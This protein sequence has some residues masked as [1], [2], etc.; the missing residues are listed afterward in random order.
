MQTIDTSQW[1]E[2]AERYAALEAAPL[3]AATVPAWLQRWSDLEA[4]IYEE[5][6]EA[7][8]RAHENTADESAEGLFIHY[9]REIQPH[10][11]QARAKLR[12]KLL[13]VTDYTPAESERVFFARFANSQALYRDENVALEAEEQLLCNQHRKLTGGM[14]VEWEGQR[15]TLTVAEQFLRVPDRELRQRAWHLIHQSWLDEREALNQQF[16]DLLA[17][18][19]QIAD[20]AGFPD[21][22]DYYWRARQRLDY[23]PALALDFHAAI[24]QEVVPLATQLYEQ[25]RNTINADR[26]RPWDEF[27]PINQEPLPVVG[28]EALEEGGARIFGAIDPEIGAMFTQ[29]RDGHLDLPVRENKAP[30]GYCRALPV[31]GRSYIFMNGVGRPEDLRTLLHEG[32]HAYHNFRS[33]HLPLLWQRRSPMEFAEVAS[34][35]MEMLAQP[36][37][38]I[39]HGGLYDAEQTRRAQLKQLR[40]IV[41]FLPY[42]AVVDAFQHWLYSDAPRDV[43]ADALD[44]QWASLWD[45]F[46]VGIDYEGLEAVKATGWHRKRHIFLYP[47]YYLEYGMAQLGALQLWQ[48]ARRDERS[49]LAAYQRALSL[50]GTQS[51]PALFETAGL[52]FAF[53]AATVHSLMDDVEDT[54]TAMGSA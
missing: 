29:L 33:F 48:N 15:M 20:N 17:L 46:M 3:S 27:A 35:G 22:R 14:T 43:G 10:A 19:R 47:F 12:D 28:M 40:K 16:L 54:M 23:D 24:E 18:R 45:R 49:A 30:G 31:S 6:G 8:S 52:R 39:R 2:L 34:M 11:E 38:D 7:T 51:L 50:G 13:A 9:V 4:Q 21:A 44:A 37:I 1:N 32:G 41:T 26:F 5:M 36:Y 53:D 42:M 25:R